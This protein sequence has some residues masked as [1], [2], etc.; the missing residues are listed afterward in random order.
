MNT[1][2]ASLQEYFLIQPRQQQESIMFYRS[3]LETRARELRHEELAHLF[4]VFSSWLTNFL[5]TRHEAMLRRRP[6]HHGLRSANPT[7]V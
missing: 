2:A 1:G 5:R 4:N 6:R 3:S 7:P